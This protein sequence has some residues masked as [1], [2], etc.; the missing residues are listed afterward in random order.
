MRIFLIA[1]ALLYVA[2]ASYARTVL[3]GPQ[4]CPVTADAAPYLAQN[5]DA[6][7]LNPW[8]DVAALATPV[9]ESEVRG[10]GDGER[11]YIWLSADARTG[12][13]LTALAGD[14]LR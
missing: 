11:N 8:Q 10:S 4:A 2:G 7:D 1:L 13:A 6:G 5:V 9:I 12:Q 14:C 3:I